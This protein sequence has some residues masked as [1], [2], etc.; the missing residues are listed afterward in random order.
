MMKLNISNIQH[1]SVGDGDGIRTTVFFKGC[2]M[3]C[4]WCHNPE[5]ISPKPQTLHFT[6]NGHDQL[7]GI[8]LD[9]DEVL[10]EI[11]EDK[12]YYAESGGGATLSGGEVMLQID[13][14]VELS[15]RLKA[16][17]ISV[18]IDTAGNVPYSYFKRMNQYADKY[19]FDWKAANAADYQKLG[20]DYELI[21]SNLKQLI[22]D[23]MDVHVRIPLIPDFNTK[24]DYVYEM[25]ERLRYTGAVNV[26]LLPFHRLGSA[27]YAALSVPYL[28][29]EVE[30][31]SNEAINEIANIYSKYFRTSVEK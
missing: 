8:Q 12:A 14:A 22:S 30:P 17:G 31:L 3:H 1:F 9:V 19:F 18:I 7:Y 29:R 26:D 24:F 5:T 15:R 16:E 21:F 13:G 27:K 20:G 11:L 10:H 6:N 25:C 28:Y 4:P 2:N 23:G